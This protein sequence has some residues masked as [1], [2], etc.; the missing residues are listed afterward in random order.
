MKRLLRFIGLLGMTA[1]AGVIGCVLAIVFGVP[2]LWRE[3]GD[4]TRE[5]TDASR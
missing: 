1:S 5:A 4:D 3:A 2:M